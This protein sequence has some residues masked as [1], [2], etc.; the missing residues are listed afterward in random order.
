MP[1]TFKT[2][3]AGRRF[4]MLTVESFVPDS[5]K[6]S[7]WTVLC[8]CGTRKSVLSQ[9]L[10]RGLTLSCGCLHRERTRKRG[11]THG[12]SGRKTRTRAYRIWANMMDRCEWGGNARAYEAYGKRGIRVC[13]EWH[14]FER[15]FASMGNPPEGTS[16][17]RI[18]NNGPYSPENCRWATRLEQALN[19]SRT[20]RVVLD[21][22]ERK[23]YD[24]CK[25]FG[26]SR[27]A[28][29]MR[30]YRMGGSYVAAL[31]SLGVQSVS[32]AA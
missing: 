17:D 31:Q 13:K 2:D 3:L 18:D 21:G 16:L 30:A 5:T 15:F 4:G 28:V 1:K 20:R 6:Y 25:Q 27:R 8:D 24:L 26:L 9:S 32:E 11:T 14:S 12:Q 19:T 10:I 7:R 22:V 29:T 23:V